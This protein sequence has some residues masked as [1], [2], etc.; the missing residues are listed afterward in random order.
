MLYPKLSPSV[1]VQLRQMNCGK[2]LRRRLCG[3]VDGGGGGGG[4]V[5]ELL[6]T[7]VVL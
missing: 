5:L 7:D 6:S 1:S 4:G 3:D 2:S